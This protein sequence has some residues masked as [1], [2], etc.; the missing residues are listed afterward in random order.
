MGQI[1][2][3]ELEK[4]GVS[5][6]GTELQDWA[7]LLGRFRIRPGMGLT[8]VGPPKQ[9]LEEIMKRTRKSEVAETKVRT[10]SLGMG[11]G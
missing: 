4:A 1:L 5:W 9:R 8:D 10:P 7:Q 2:V 6:E 11:A 3:P